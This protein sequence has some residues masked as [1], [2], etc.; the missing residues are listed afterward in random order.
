MN[1]MSYSSKRQGGFGLI[2]IMVAGQND[3]RNFPI[4]LSSGP[5]GR[6]PPDP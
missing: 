2:E 1:R 3:D 4:L 5:L 6:S